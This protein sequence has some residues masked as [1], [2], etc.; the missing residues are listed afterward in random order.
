MDQLP[1]GISVSLQDYEFDSHQKGR[2]TIPLLRVTIAGVPTIGGLVALM[3]QLRLITRTIKGEYIAIT[4]LSMLEVNK[5]FESFILFGMEK[6]YK[7]FLSVKNQAKISFVVLGKK[8]NN[9]LISDTLQ[10]INRDIV[11]E[12]YSYKYYF[13]EDESKIGELVEKGM[14]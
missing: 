11:K 10:R 3:K 4:D 12:D 7:I 6:S 14:K 2:S 9:R 8:Q 1:K 13:L 5:V